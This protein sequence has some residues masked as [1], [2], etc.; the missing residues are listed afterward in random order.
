L[1][2]DKTAEKFARYMKKYPDLYQNLADIVKKYATNAKPVVIDLGVGPGLLSQE[3]H[4][5]IPNAT[6]IGVDPNKKML[7]LAQQNAC[8]DTFEARLGSSENI[9]VDDD[10]ADIVVSRFSL[11][12]WKDQKKSFSEMFRV[13]KKDGCIILEVINK[14]FPIWRLF[15]IKVHM[16]FNKAGADVTKYHI[17]VYKDAY[18]IDQVEQFFFNAGFF[19]VEKEGNRKEWKF[20]IVGK[21]K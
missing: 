1:I 17:D 18:T 7:S 15:L 20:L 12:Y 8:F 14:D 4:I 11:T 3:L 19:V 10:S 9:P 2:D 21:K 5:Q 13:L 6:I 16:L